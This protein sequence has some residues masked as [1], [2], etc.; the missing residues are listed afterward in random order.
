[1]KTDKLKTADELH[2][3]RLRAFILLLIKV[4]S[5]YAK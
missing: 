2:M 1:M 3:E 4:A 5:I